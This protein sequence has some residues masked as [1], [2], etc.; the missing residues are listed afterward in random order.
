MVTIQ[1]YDGDIP[2]NNNNIMSNFI[3]LSAQNTYFNANA[4]LTLTDDCKFTKY[5]EPILINKSFDELIQYKYGRINISG[6]NW[7]YFSIAKFVIETSSKTWMFIDIDPW[8]TFRYRANGL[9]LGRGHITRSSR[10]KNTKIKTA[11][12]PKF[13]NTKEY[14]YLRRYSDLYLEYCTIILSHNSQDDTNHII[15]LYVT[16][17]DLLEDLID[18]HA[19]I[20]GVRHWN[21]T[22]DDVIGVWLSP[23]M[24]DY[25]AP[26]QQPTMWDGYDIGNLHYKETSYELFVQNIID[27]T[28]PQDVTLSKMINPSDKRTIG[29][30]DLRDNL[31]WVS[32]NESTYKTSILFSLSISM[33]ACA[34][35]GY[36]KKD[37]NVQYSEGLF[38]IPCETIDIFNDAFI[39]Y[40]V[41]Q[42]PFIER[43]RAIQREQALIN[44]IGNIGQTAVMG[45]IG[46]NPYGAIAGAIVGAV[47]SGIDY[48][49][50]DYYNKQYQENEDRQAKAQTDTL[51]INGTAIVD[52]LLGRTYLKVVTIESDTQ[53]LAE[54][55]KDVS[56]F[57]NYYDVEDDLEQ[58]IYDD[59]NLTANTSEIQNIPSIYVPNIQARLSRG[60]IF[61]DPS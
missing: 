52:I 8:E 45:G 59:A 33:G 49:S 30:T 57:G 5:E 41:Q 16:D 4:D 44:S 35:N 19:I 1:L 34:W 55:E 12:T 28:Q 61:I 13:K 23:F 43:Q 27:G 31:V 46:G 17:P 11:L 37:D 48:F 22:N 7:V 42:R 3:D 18:N 38:S 39:L 21:M 60:V 10:N 56:T 58:W 24:V 14:N 6:S 29:I 26:E 36:I 2:F 40:N 47:G 51:R 20:T 32:D 15:I 50:A 9:E 53:S 54:Y 25:S